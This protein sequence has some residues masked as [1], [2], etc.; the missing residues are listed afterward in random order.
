MDNKLVLH[1]RIKE[2]KAEKKISQ[3]ELAKMVGIS[4]NNIS[5]IETG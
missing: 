2:I 5:S 1:N 3:A 4:R